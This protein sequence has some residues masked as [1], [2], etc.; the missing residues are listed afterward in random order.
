MC[1]E[2]GNPLYNQR[3]PILQHD[4]DYQR[5]GSGRCTCGVHQGKPNGVDNHETKL[6]TSLELRNSSHRP[7]LVLHC[8]HQR[9]Q[10]THI[11]QRRF[12]SLAIWTDL[13]RQP[14]PCMMDG[15]VDG[16]MTNLRYNNLFK[17]SMTHLFMI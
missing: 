9:W 5:G 15:W 14:V 1:K 17:S 16:W 10:I 12:R 13:R 8:H 7:S 3:K 4:S 11:H 6:G 2:R